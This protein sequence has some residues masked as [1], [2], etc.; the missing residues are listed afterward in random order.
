MSDRVRIHHDGLHSSRDHRSADRRDRLHRSADRR[1]SSLSH[2]RNLL[3]GRS[4]G[5]FPDR[6]G[7]GR[8][9]P[10]A[11]HDDT[12][13]AYQN[14]DRVPTSAAHQGKGESRWRS[15]PCRYRPVLGRC[16]WW[17]RPWLKNGG[18]CA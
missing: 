2:R 5:L 18:K 17:R 11:P 6:G 9:I 8:R 14:R 12:A 4:L 16:W 1:G 15:S 13:D 3:G 7:H 10:G